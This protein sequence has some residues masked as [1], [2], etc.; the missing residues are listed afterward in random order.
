MHDYVTLPLAQL[1]VRL[2]VGFGIDTYTHTSNLN[3]LTKHADPTNNNKSLSRATLRRRI[4]QSKHDG[5]Y[6]LPPTDP[7]FLRKCLR[8]H[9]HP[10]NPPIKE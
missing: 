7:D 6:P 2:S 9:A 3:N 8:A 4:Q 1:T 5:E 10:N